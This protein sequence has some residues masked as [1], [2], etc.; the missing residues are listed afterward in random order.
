MEKATGALITAEVRYKNGT[1]ARLF[2]P[3]DICDVRGDTDNPDRLFFLAE[4]KEGI[5]YGVNLYL[6]S[7]NE[8]GYGV[9]LAVDGIN[10]L[11][12][13]KIP[14]AIERQES[15]D[16]SYVLLWKSSNGGMINGWQETTEEAREFVVKDAS[17]SYAAKM[18]GD[19]SAMGT[20]ALA[21]FRNANDSIEAQPQLIAKGTARSIGTGY[22]QKIQQKVVSTTFESK[23]TAYELIVIKLMTTEE[24]T[25]LGY[26]PLAPAQANEQNRLWPQGQE[27]CKFP[28]ETPAKR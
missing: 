23:R 6:N 16:Q 11:S 20:I 25:R 10:T 3:K 22:G 12:G 26:L 1:V 28:E 7:R 4:A 19:F 5:P 21:I 15:W 18:F 13:K 9:G 17:E 14:S 8:L 27:F 2:K 24:L